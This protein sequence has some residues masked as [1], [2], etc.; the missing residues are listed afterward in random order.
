MKRI[1]ILDILKGVCIIFIILDHYTLWGNELRLQLLFPYWITMA[2]PI[3]MILSGYVY[4]M[5][6]ERHNITTLKSAYHYRFILDK[7]IRYTIPF[8]LAYLLEFAISGYDNG[9]V[10]ILDDWIRGL[11]TGGWGPG[12]YYYPIMIQFIFVFPIIYFIIKRYDFTGLILC[13]ILNALYEWLQ[14]ACDLS[15]VAYRLL[16]FRYLLLIA[17]GCYVL[18]G[19][20]KPNHLASILITMIGAAFIWIYNYKGYQP[21]VLTQWTETCFIAS[22]FI[23]PITGFILKCDKIHSISFKPLELIGKA[24]F[25]IFLVQMV[26]FNYV[27]KFVYR[28]GYSTITLNV[29]NLAICIIAGIFFYYIESK[30]TGYILTKVRSKN[31]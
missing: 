28:L 3:L 11:F 31:L 12:S 16:L 9:F 22:F 20:K 25:N 2:V 4:S 23:M 18:L 24:S 17:F 10:A 14:Y 29:I 19:K 13:G 21:I 15:Y 5:S 8:L 6:Y 30:I 1:K 7:Y 26:Y 27:A